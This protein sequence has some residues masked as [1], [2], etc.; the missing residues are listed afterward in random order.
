ME[1]ELRVCVKLL[2]TRTRILEIADAL[3]LAAVHANEPLSAFAVLI[4][5]RGV[6][7]PMALAGFSLQC[8]P[9]KYTVVDFSLAGGTGL[10]CLT[11]TTQP[12]FL[13]RVLLPGMQTL[14]FTSECQPTNAR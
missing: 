8:Y 13:S 5:L 12:E 1:W 11:P 4:G 3:D 7:L 2:G 6:A 14:S 10:G 9:V